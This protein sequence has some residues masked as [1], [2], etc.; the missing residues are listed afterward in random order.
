MM[1]GRSEATRPGQFCVISGCGAGACA[2]SKAPS[3]EEKSPTTTAS[4]LV[5][6]RGAMPGIA[7]VLPCEP[8]APMARKRDAR[9]ALRVAQNLPRI[10]MPRHGR[11]AR[12][13]NRRRPRTPPEKTDRTLGRS[14]RRHDEA[15]RGHHHPAAVLLADRVHA[16]QPRHNVALIDLD[17]AHA[18][19]DD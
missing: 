10:A 15:L 14:T 18:A 2:R 1:R 16:T 13:Q 17:D 8:S 9:A 12:K 3:C 7:V 5:R 19:F 4:A 11:R 6:T